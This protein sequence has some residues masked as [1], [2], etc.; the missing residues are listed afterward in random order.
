MG[1]LLQRVEQ[2]AKKA[3][4]DVTFKRPDRAYVEWLISSDIIVNLI[5]LHHDYP[6][7]NQERGTLH[8]RYK[9]LYKVRL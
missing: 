5:P 3:E 7:L 1:A 9:V 2:C 6:F 8:Q 4:A